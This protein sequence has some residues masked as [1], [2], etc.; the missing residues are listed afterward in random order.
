MRL[1]LSVL[2]VLCLLFLTFAVS[3]EE[4]RLELDKFLAMVEENSLDLAGARTDRQL[5]Q[6]Q[7]QLAKSAIYPFIA[8]EAGYTRNLTELTQTFPGSSGPVEIPINTDNEFS[9]GISVQQAVFDMKAFRGVEASQEYL[10]LTGAAYESARQGILTMA[11]KLF[12]QT[13]LL[14]AVLDVRKSSEENAYENYTE[15]QAKFDNGV[16]SKM[17]VLRAEVNWKVTIPET[18]QAAKNLDI[19]RWNLKNMAGIDSKVNLVPVGS[20]LEYPS[21]PTELSM[22]EI[23]AVRPDVQTLENQQILREIN[24]DAMRA[25]FYPTLSANFTYGLQAASNK[26]DVSDPTEIISAGLTVSIPIFYGGSRFAQLKQAQLELEQTMTSID[27]KRDDVGTEIGTIRLSL[28]EAAARIESAK[29]TLNTAEQA[30]TITKT[31]VE[32]GLATQ[33]ELKD[34]RLSREAAQLQYYSATFDYLNSYFDWQAAT[35]KGAD[36]P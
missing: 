29:Q 1:P 33:L 21:L 36:I 2:L 20:L 32:N 25:E 22:G 15:T 12:Y 18:S 30:Y 19:A 14:Q 13:L 31:S 8:G 5:A 4:T 24:I 7:E 26:F 28:R 17:E 3:A 10:N 34:S 23:L 6:V 9:F 35:G 11:K 16:A 27:K